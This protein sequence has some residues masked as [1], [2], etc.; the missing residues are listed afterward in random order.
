MLIMIYWA[1]NVNK[2]NLCAV[3]KLEVTMLLGS[4]GITDGCSCNVVVHL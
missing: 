1:D 3:V 2:S 4:G